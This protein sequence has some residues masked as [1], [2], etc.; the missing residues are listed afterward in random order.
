MSDHTATFH[1]TARAEPGLR[2]A[3]GRVPMVI[4]GVGGA[5]GTGALFSGIAMAAVAGPA[6]IISWVIG[7]V[8]YSFIG[9]SYV[10]MSVRFPEAGGPARY[11]LYT[12]GAMANLINSVGSL[13]WYLFIPPVEAVA[14]VE[15][16]SHFDGGL[17]TASGTPTAAGALVA[18]GL[19]VLYVPF[20]YYGVRFFA[21]ITNVLGGGKIV[22]YVLLALG[23]LLVLSHADN[24]T[25]F[26]GF[27]PFGASAVFAAVP[28]AMF[29]FGGIRVLP[30]FA[31]EVTETRSLKTGILY[32]LG[33]QTIIYL[34]FSVAFIGGISWS[35]LSVKA[36]AWGALTKVAGNP[37][38]V[39]STNRGVGW[40]LVV[41]IVVG[42]IGPGVVGYVYQG[43][44]TRV[45]MSMARTGYV[46][47]R[48]KTVSSKHEI[49]ISALLVIA[50]VGA[51]LGLLTAPVPKIYSLINDAVVGG[52][53]SFGAVPAAMLA[54]RRQKGERPS[55]ASV[56]MA[57]LGFGGASV[58]VYWSGWPAVPYAVILIAIGVIAFG[59]YSRVT[60]LR[61]AAWY[62]TWVL[63]LTL[64]AGI[65]SVGKATLISFNAGSIIVAAV[66]ILLIL[67]WAVQSRLPQLAGIDA[68]D[69]R[70]PSPTQ[71]P[72]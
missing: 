32:T 70:A 48:L 6:M 20:N 42:I 55:V 22:L 27:A 4:I 5:V 52:Y 71:P 34:L 37:F 7:A 64:M 12:H 72:S 33:I 2:K 63:F 23:F 36:G 18:L 60:G 46:P 57:A 43:A 47:S 49:P 38:I 66:S 59:L 53:V 39:L 51:I 26:G 1:E 14:T 50:V 30:D 10:D 19:L 54:L 3:I 40:L 44:G 61:H 13:V 41:A 24:F 11:A 62:V 58:I 28:V 16:I 56:V 21:R 17:L 8:I 35:T 69:V 9:M 68:T 25:S 31:E 65:G 15:G 67:P 29:A 45:L